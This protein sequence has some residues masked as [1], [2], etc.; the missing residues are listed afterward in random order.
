M[1]STALL[2]CAFILFVIEGVRTKSTMC[3][4]F[5]CWTLSKLVGVVL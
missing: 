5:A 4:A 3:A 1:L 2:L